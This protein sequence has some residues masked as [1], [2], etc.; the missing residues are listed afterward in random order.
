MLDMSELRVFMAIIETGGFQRASRQLRIS[1]PAVSQSIANLE[2]KLGQKILERSAPVRPTA[3]GRHLLKSARFILDREAEFLLDVERMQNG[4]LQN[5]SLV[6]DYLINDMYAQHYISAALKRAPELSFT[7]KRLPARKMISAVLDGK[8]DMGIGPFQKRMAKLHT[9]KLFEESAVLITGKKNPHLKTYPR[10]P[11][12][13]LSRTVLLA[14]FVDE[15]EDRPSKKK[16]RDYFKEVWEV[17]T[18]TLQLRLIEQ[19]IGA[20]FVPAAVLKADPNRKQWVK[21]TKVPFAEISKPYGLYYPKDTA[22]SPAAEI[23]VDAVSRYAG[24]NR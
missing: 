4:Y 2:R 1:Q 15:P 11:L 17:N 8:C 20:T 7:V 24:R 21:L 23:F 16:I 19:G 18:L 5:I 13:F 12:G 9:I 3:I 14:S 6:I 22:L 10:N